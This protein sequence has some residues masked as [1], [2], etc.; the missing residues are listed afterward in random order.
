MTDI[1]TDEFSWLADQ[2]SALGLSSD[3]PDARRERV[4]TTAGEI[5][6][7]RFGDAE[8]RVVF[9]HGAG[10]NAHTF[11]TTILA[12]GAPAVSIDLPGHGDSD[13]RE[14]AD[15]SPAAIGPAVAEA[16]AA[17]TDAPITLVGHSLGGLTAAWIAAHHPELVASLVILDV[18]PGIDPS[19]GPQVLRAF[20]A[21]IEFPDRA[22]VADWSESFGLG[23]SRASLERGV[24]FNTRIRPDGVVEWKHHF[25]R[26]AHD[27]LPSAT[28]EGG[29]VTGT[30][31]WDDLAAVTAPIT[32]VRATAGFVSEANAEVY[33]DRLPQARVT[34][35]AGGHNLQETDPSGLASLIRTLGAL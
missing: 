8:A 18:T 17:L 31:G 21:A 14:D 25:A 9:L 19:A 32:L 23:G 5:S 20:Y 11:D 22:A 30:T 7:L 6:A 35:L 1:I 27:V 24:Y 15:Y 33:R 34:E 3:L 12:L 13:W 2:A 4:S 29:S 26:I 10:L 16:I 28:G